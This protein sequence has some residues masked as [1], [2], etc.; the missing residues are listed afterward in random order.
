MRALSHIRNIV[1]LVALA[2]G[3]PSFAQSWSGPKPWRWIFRVT[4]D[5]HYSLSDADIVSNVNY[6]QLFAL[7][8][9]GSLAL[10]HMFSR[11]IYFGARYE[12]WYAQRKMT[13]SGGNE[14]NRLD[15]QSIAAELGFRG[16]NAR[17]FW[18][19]SFAMGYPT[20]LSV[21]SSSGIPYITSQK[22]FSYE[23]RATVGL[24]LNSFFTLLFEGGYRFVDLGD[25]RNESFGSFLNGGNSLNMSGPFGG[26][27]IGFTF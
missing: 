5:L 11:F 3:T 19:V 17:S 22:P 13:G 24:R 2:A 26:G 21:A 9:V 23:G 25:L 7:G 18:M 8:G 12:Y 27:G 14:E 15:Y 6:S 16:G 20:K 4:G 1:L 10:G